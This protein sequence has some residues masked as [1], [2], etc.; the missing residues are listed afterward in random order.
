MSIVISFVGVKGGAGKSTLAQAVAVEWARR[1]LRVLLVCLDKKQRSSEKWAAQRATLG[2]GE[3]GPAVIAMREN[4]RTDFERTASAYDLAII[5]TRGD[6]GELPVAALAL[7]HLA[8]M[9]C[10]PN[11]I[12]V[13]AMEETFAE[14]ASVRRKR[15]ELDAVVVITRKQPNTVV[16]REARKAYKGC[17]FDVC[18][19]ELDFGLD[20]GQAHDAGQGPTEWKPK[21]KAADET[22]ALCDA[23]QARLKIKLP[24]R[25]RAVREQESAPS[26]AVR[27]VVAS[28]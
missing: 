9:P 12:E 8:V 22:R 5:D 19:V 2:R 28:G 13:A 7:S 26:K 4:I 15:P 21:S 17:G 16:G 25:K 6:V 1:G 3:H 11:G 27:K 14:V 23:L 18:R 24:R 10:G 20:Y